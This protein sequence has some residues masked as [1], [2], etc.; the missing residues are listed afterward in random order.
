MHQKKANDLGKDKIV[1]LVLKLAIPT[2]LAQFIN[3]LY[4]VVDRMF[5]GH[6]PGIGT[7]A[8]AGVGICGPIIAVLYAFCYLI[9]QGGT[10]VMAMALGAGNIQRAEV[11]MANALR[12]LIRMGLSLTVIFLLI[13]N[14]LLWWFGA[15]PAIFPYA[16]AFLTIYLCG[17]VFALLSGG[18]NSFLIA[19]GHA[20]L[21]VGTVLAGTV[22]NL[23]LDPILIFGMHLG[24]AGAAIATVISQ[25]ISACFAIICLCRM[26]LTARLHWQKLDSALCRQIIHLG[27]APFFTYALDSGLLILLNTILQRTGGPTEGNMLVT[28]ATLIQSY[29][30]LITSPLSGITMGCQGIVSFNLGAHKVERVKAALWSIYAV[31][32]AF[33]FVMLMFTLFATPV[34]VRLFT[35]DAYLIQRAVPY[36]KL[37][38]SGVLFMAVQWTVTDM[39]IAMEQPKVALTC[40]LLRKGIYV[41]G[42]VALP[43]CFTPAMA[44][45]AQPLCDF[46]AAVFSGVVFIHMVP[47]VLVAHRGFDTNEIK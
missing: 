24:V 26:P 18:M 23:I 33:C 43:L 11:V 35:A 39:S 6:I 9:G 47:R 4:S 10:P 27:L 5:I 16:S 40:S 13:R 17:T 29:M 19:Q 45:A 7:D 22:L 8:L 15:S 44:F 32:F 12:L 34:F 20:G 2:M 38:A 21:G 1:S 46:L 31:C 14:Q 42:V 41:L 30:L 28:C 37:Y 36:I 3:V 25:T